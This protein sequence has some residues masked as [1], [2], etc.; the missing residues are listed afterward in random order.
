MGVGV[1]FGGARIGESAGRVR[2]TV[3]ATGAEQVL[4][5]PIVD[6]RDGL[7]RMADFARCKQWCNYYTRRNCRN[8]S[9]RGAWR[10]AV[11]PTAVITEAVK[12]TIRDLSPLR[13]C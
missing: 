2:H 4:N 7:R 1:R 6:H 8:W 9:S 13:R 5:R 11:Q 10:R 3:V 12:A